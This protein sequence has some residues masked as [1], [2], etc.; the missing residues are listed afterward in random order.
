MAARTRAKGPAR[1]HSA[2]I[3]ACEARSVEPTGVMTG[4]RLPPALMTGAS[5]PLR[6]TVLASSLALGGLAAPT[7]TAFLIA[8][9]TPASAD[10]GR[11]GGPS[12]GAG[13]GDG[14][15]GPGTPGGPGNGGGGGGAGYDLVGAAGG[16]GSG[17]G[18]N[19]GRGGLH[20]RV[21]PILVPGVAALGGNGAAGDTGLVAGGG[22]GGGAGGYGTV[23]TGP[24]GT[25]TI[26]WSS[27]GGNGGNG[28]ASLTG[29]GGSG[30]SGGIGFLFTNGSATTT[31]TI[32]GTILGGNGGV[33]GTGGGG[34]GTH[35]AGGVGLVGRNLAI[36][37]TGSGTISGG[38][39]GDGVTRA[40]AIRFISG[41]NE[42]RFNGATTGLTGGIAI[43][44]GLLNIVPSTDITVSNVI[45]GA[46]SI[47][48][49][50]SGTLTLSGANTFSGGTRIHSGVLAVAADTNLGAAAGAVT[51][52]GATAYVPSTGAGAAPILRTTADFSSARK[53]VFENFGGRIETDA[54][55]TLTLTGALTGGGG[56][57]FVKQG[58]GTLVLTGDSSSAN[59]ATGFLGTVRVDGGTLR[60]ENGGRLGSASS[61]GGYISAG[62]GVVV[63]GSGS[64]WTSPGQIIVGDRGAGTLRIENQGKVASQVGIIGSGGASSATITGAGSEWATISTDFYVGHFSS[65]GVLTVSD[66]GALRV[67]SAGTG[68]VNAG[69]FT[70][71]PGGTINIGAV[72]TDPAAAAGQLLATRVALNATASR[73]VFN[74]TDTGYGFGLVVSGAGAVR[75][76]AGTTILTAVNSYSGGTELVGG[77]L[78][79]AADVH[80]GDLTGGLRFAGG[81]LATTASFVS[82]RGVTLTGAGR[83]DVAVGTELGLSGAVS[84]PGDLVKAGAGTLRLGGAANAY[85]R[86]LVETGTLI[87][88][89]RSISGT[90][91]NA[92]T[93]VFEQAADGTFA[94]AIGSL[95]GTSG[96]MVKRGAGTLAL[97][98]ASALDWT[99]EAGGLTTAAERFA[100]NAAIAAGA[101]LTFDQAANGAYAGAL[102]GAGGLV[103]VGAGAL[104]IDGNNAGFTGST[105]VAAGALI[106]GS[107]TAHAGAVLGG[108][109]DVAG[110]ATLGGHGTVGSGAGSTVAIGS[111]GTLSPGN[112]IGTLTVQGNLTFAAGA[113]YRIE[114][115]PLGSDRT[116]VSGIA[117]LG[118][119]TVAAIYAPGSYVT[120]RYTILTA[121]SVSGT[122][123][124]PVN[125]NL[126]V[127]FTTALASDATGA[128]LDLTYAPP[129]P[130]FGA[131]LTVNQANVA[132][133]LVNSFN[134]AGGIPLAFGALTAP[135]LS[136]ASGEAATGIQQATVDVMDRFLTLMTDPFANGRNTSATQMADLGRAPRGVI[137]TEPVR[138]SAWASGYGGVQALGGNATIGSHGTSTSIYGTAVGADYRVSPDTMIG[139]ALG[140]AG[141]SYRLGQ[142]LGGGSS[143]VFQIGLYGRHQ[144]GAAY[145][146]AALAYGW[147]DV[148]T[149]RRFMGDRLTGRFTTQAFSGRIETGY[150]FALGFAG[151]TP[152]AAGQFVSY[153]LPDY[154]EQAT[155]GSGLFALDYAGRSA[156]AWRTELGLRADK[157]IQL[158][159]AELVLRGRLAW[160]H[161]FNGDRFVGAS[162]SSLPASSF[163]VHGASQAADMLLTSAGAELKWANGWSAAATFEGGFSARGNSY[164]GRGTLRYQW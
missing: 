115:S 75:Q 78:Q 20:G 30:G 79:V 49:I 121:G 125:T 25:A 122:F 13:G 141:T 154:R 101:R 12:G 131:G 44:S 142:G 114:V 160:A 29:E 105:T 18:G 128:Y 8:S 1:R 82:A 93:V 134:S 47:A 46:G 136:G 145:I 74:H 107:D 89:A 48:M 112:S 118:G 60:I 72:A 73:L 156:T 43:Q 130:D 6:A 35:G 135:G 70:S 11:G 10:G 81:T 39:S 157:A 120:K 68:T 127:N 109:L 138:W 33:A 116:N 65:T 77:T 111:G 113:T 100:G 140:A 155:S 151:L 36:T 40:D 67:G 104:L 66:S 108:S 159:E 7:F 34:D 15:D 96:Q 129:R 41:T 164:A 24:V 76:I 99:V 87:G 21:G 56:A 57:N 4:E 22:G 161:N 147:Q 38:L 31:L 84:G 71:S 102:S 152:Y 86:T 2:H 19:G 150:R 117:T 103:K 27:T 62:A 123:A 9:A 126:P 63:T 55:T 52:F 106:V 85:G 14:A 119:A 3:D 50:G 162:F 23:V 32:S 139:F 94:G 158:G 144:M 5:L 163:I 45:S 137:V 153:A 69:I 110:G 28:G 148:T 64:A 59:M 92:A 88:D 98:G 51:L 61:G 133:A 17:G 54:G 80:L 37:M 143:D 53:I 97:S 90:I 58:D 124:G 146:A 83:F 16:P 149:E 26:N 42:L 91:G 95:G 132:A